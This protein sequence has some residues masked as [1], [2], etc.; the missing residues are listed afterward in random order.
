M[1]LHT[2]TSPKIDMIRREAAKKAGQGTMRGVCHHGAPAM[3]LYP[4]QNP[5]MQG[6][7]KR[8]KRRLA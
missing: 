4:L 8:D 5:C 2:E 1:R 3:R 6:R 7:N